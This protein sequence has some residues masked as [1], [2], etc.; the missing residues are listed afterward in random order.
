MNVPPTR[1]A[2][3]RAAHRLIGLGGAVFLLILLVTGVGLQHT[4]DLGLNDTFAASPALLHWWG[5][6]APTR[7]TAYRADDTEV[8]ELGGRLFVNGQGVLDNL[9]ALVGA[10]AVGDLILAAGPSV[11]TVTTADGALVDH[12]VTPALVDR[13]GKLGDTAVIGTE[14]GVLIADDSLL[15]WGPAGSSDAVAWSKPVILGTE[16]LASLQRLYLQRTLSWERVV[17]DLH[18]GRVLGPFG[19][20]LVDLVAFALIALAITGLVLSR[21]PRP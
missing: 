6:E 21:R 19:P 4:D 9:N 8:V 15:S 3:I 7:Y 17:A 18:S 14:T 20:L 2:R 12:M 11:L 5:I 16:T 1:F 13:V 10:V